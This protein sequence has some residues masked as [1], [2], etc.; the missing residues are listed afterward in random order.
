MRATL[1]ELAEE[2]GLWIPLAP[3]GEVIEADGYCLVTS[4]RSASVERIRLA[5]D[6]VE[7]AIEE[8][9]A[10]AR[11]RHFDHVTWWL[12]EHTT[13]A[14]LPQRLEGLGFEPDRHTPKMTT[15]TIDRTPAGKPTV[16]VHR[17]STADEYLRALELDWDV[18]E[19]PESER[20][21]MRPLQR[22]AWPELEATGRSSHYLAYL[23][24]E[25][26]GFARA[27]FTT[28]AAILLGG[29]TL[30]GARGRGVYTSLV[31]ARW[32]ETVERGV[33]RIVVSAGP[34]SAPILERLGFEAIGTV[35]LLRDRL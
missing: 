21:G 11:E 25:P 14:G 6:E 9:R 3:P 13:P 27:V 29:S 2:P 32:R 12:G 35:R 23:D 24:G 15:L 4:L 30:P 26:A 33:P 22:R 7:R 10:L 18:W 28:H 17:V 19:V 16:E 5:P 8:I 31:H 20:A 1:L 34:M